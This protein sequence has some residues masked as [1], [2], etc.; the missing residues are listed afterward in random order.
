[1]KLK[2][3]SIFVGELTTIERRTGLARTVELRMVYLDGKFYAASRRVQG[4]HW[5]RNMLKNPDMNVKAGGE[6]FSGRARQVADEGLRLR[7]LN[8]RD[9]PPLSERVVFEMTPRNAPAAN[10]PK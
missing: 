3:E 8:P 7:V 9:S 6:L 1:M 5:G 4:K 10:S 2:N